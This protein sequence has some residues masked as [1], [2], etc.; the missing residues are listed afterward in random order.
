M[1]FPI[2]KIIFRVVRELMLATMVLA[3]AALLHFCASR[4][5]KTKYDSTDFI[6]QI[7]TGNRRR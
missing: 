6:N 5:S 4:V 7:L 3:L 2:C 1:E